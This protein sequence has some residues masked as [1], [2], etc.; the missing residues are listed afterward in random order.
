MAKD[1]DATE[2]SYVMKW[3]VEP[4]DAGQRLDHFL[5]EK[6]RKRSREQIKEAI[7]DGLVELNYQPTKPARVLRL[8]DKVYV[9]S[10]KKNEPIVDFNYRTIFED[11]AIIVVD[12]PGNLPV[13]PTGRFFFNTLLTRMQ[14]VNN[15]EV[16][17]NR[18][19]YLVHRIDRE[20]SG[21]L[22]IARDAD[23][24]AH[25]TKQFNDRKT[26]KEYLAIARG[27]MELD[28]QTVNLP[29]GKDP[30][31]LVGLK[32]S[33]VALDAAGKPLYLHEDAVLQAETHFKVLERVGNYTVV[34]VRPHTGRQHQIRVHLDAVGHPIAGDKLYGQAGTEVFLRNLQGENPHVEVEPGLSLSRHA[35]H[36]A[37]LGFTHPKTGEWMEFEAAFPEELENFLVQVRNKASN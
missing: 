27:R 6:Y 9:R 23:S 10:E 34:R 5:K 24:C 20:T 22:V 29:L 16:D 14:T 37:C 2:N 26:K 15:N 30:H 21:L 3:T 12:K 11:D 33:T 36:A 18:Q 35:L 32:M 17:Q 7:H 4:Y 1:F 13:H 8:N 19:F 25:L 31:S 28:E